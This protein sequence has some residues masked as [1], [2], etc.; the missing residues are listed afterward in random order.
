[1]GKIMRKIM[2]K[3]RREKQRKKVEKLTN[4]R[5]SIIFIYKNHYEQVTSRK[6]DGSQ[7]WRF[8]YV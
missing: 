3:S 8:F 2:R 4:Y 7:V 6:V 1:M 5:L